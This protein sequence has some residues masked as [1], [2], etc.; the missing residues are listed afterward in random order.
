MKITKNYAKNR[1]SETNY[2]MIAALASFLACF[3]YCRFFATFSL[4][5]SGQYAGFFTCFLLVGGIGFLLSLFGQRNILS[6]V[7]VVLLPILLYD[8]VQMWKYSDLLVWLDLSSVLVA[9]IAAFFYTKRKTT[10]IRRPSLKKKVRIGVASQVM[11]CIVCGFLLIGVITCKSWI[12]HKKTVLL[13]E[14]LYQESDT[15]EDVPDYENS[16]D[17][18]I[19]I[20]SKLD[21]AGGWAEL[22]LEEKTEVLA[23]VIRVECRY[24][25]MATAPSLKIAYL[26]DHTLGSYNRETDTVTLSYQYI[27]DENASGYG[28]LETLLHELFHRYERVQTDLLAA[29][30]ENPDL[31]EYQKLLLFSDASTYEYEFENYI[32]GSDGSTYSYLRYAS[33]SVEVDAERY[34]NNAIVSD[35][36]TRIQE[37][38]LNNAS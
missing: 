20:I 7:T 16:L 25:G 30:R 11:R 3:L 14:V 38:L 35:Y 24:F 5:S 21:P 33:Q 32:S 36:Y 4:D 22:S 1:F 34:A 17:Y 29:I 12:N 10:D 26:E 2:L 13:K 27:V 8:S 19:G 37:H 9:G 28:V 15:V 31:A 23:A 6:L 18:N